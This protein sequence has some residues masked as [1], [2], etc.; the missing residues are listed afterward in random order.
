[1]N[2]TK[3]TEAEQQELLAYLR[4]R[5]EYEPVSGRLRNKRQGT[6]QKPVLRNNN[7]C[8]IEVCFKSRLIPVSVHVAVWAVCKGEWPRNTIDHINND[9]TDNHIENLREC[10]MSENLL[11]VIHPWVP[12][13]ETGVPG[14]SKR[15][16]RN[17]KYRTWIAGKMYLFYSPYE[18]FY[19]ATLCGKMYGKN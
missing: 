11:N 15:K 4:A 19:Y 7:Y 10:S 1:M 9:P 17:K 6:V 8:K 5:Y 13:I 12:N 2:R 3:R 18:A 14:V 16:K